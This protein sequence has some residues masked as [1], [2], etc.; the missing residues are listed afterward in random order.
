MPLRFT[1]EEARELWRAR[2]DHVARQRLRSALGL[3]GVLEVLGFLLVGRGDLA[4]IFVGTQALLIWSGLQELRWLGRRTR[5]WWQALGLAVLLGI[6]GSGLQ[7]C[8]TMER[9]VA[10]LHGITVDPLPG[11]CAPASLQA[12]YCIKTKQASGQ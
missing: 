9:E 3:C 10:K 8:E 11:P 7:G 6:A 2:D 1:R 12:G 5:A 4:V